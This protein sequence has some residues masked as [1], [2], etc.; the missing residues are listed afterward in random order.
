M[1]QD[2]CGGSDPNDQVDRTSV[3]LVNFLLLDLH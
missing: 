1:I 2:Q 3:D